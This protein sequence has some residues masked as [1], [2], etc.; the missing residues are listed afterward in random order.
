MSTIA[1]LSVIDSSNEV[2]QVGVQALELTAA[3]FTAQLALQEALWTAVL[4][5]SLGVRL[6]SQTTVIVPN[7]AAAPAAVAAQRESK[8]LISYRDNSPLVPGGGAPNAGYGKYFNI[9]IP[10][11]DVLNGDLFVAGTDLGNWQGTT[12]AAE[13]TA[14]VTAFQGYAR[15][16][17]G[18]LPLVVGVEFVG[19]RN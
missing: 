7:V 8:W 6:K 17:Y 11:A 14:F 13:W 1:T 9:E 16:P 2:A 18:G 4:G 5:V 15:S 3:N 10:V 12:V 19:R